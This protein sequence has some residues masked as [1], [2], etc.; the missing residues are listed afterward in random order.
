VGVR[1]VSYQKWPGALGFSAFSGLLL[2]DGSL[3]AS[4]V[5]QTTFDRE[6]VIG[7]N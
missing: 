5:N 3:R 6:G 1:G 2:G 4:G 7:G